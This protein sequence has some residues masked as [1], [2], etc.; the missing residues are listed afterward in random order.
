M[1][2]DHHVAA[3]LDDLKEGEKFFLGKSGG[4]HREKGEMRKE[5]GG[6]GCSLEIAPPH[7]FVV[8]S[9]Y[10]Q[11]ESAVRG[12]L[13]AKKYLRQRLERLDFCLGVGSTEDSATGNDCVATCF[14]K[15]FA[16][17]GIYATVHFDDCL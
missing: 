14:G 2:A 8:P 10:E 1:G 6:G 11:G 5:K 12:V 9:P 15:E 4:E 3:V 7:H 16:R 17:L 13:T